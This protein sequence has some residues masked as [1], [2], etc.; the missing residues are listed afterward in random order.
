[1]ESTR[2]RY[3][4]S[5]KDVDSLFPRA[6]LMDKTIKRGATVSDT[7][8]FIPQAV[9]MTR[10]QTQKLTD[11]FF[12]GYDLRETCRRIVDFVY[13][14]IN[15]RKDEDGLEQIRS[16]RRSWH[17][18]LTGV[19][20]DCYTTFISTI[21]TNLRIKHKLRIAKYSEDH[22]QHIYP[23][24]PLPQG[25]YLTLDC[26]PMPRRFNYEEPYTE[27]KDTN[28]NLEF[29]DG[30]PEDEML[31]IDDIEGLGKTKLGKALKKGLHSFNRVNPATIAL[32]NGLLAAMKL[33]TMNIAG[34]IRW[35]YLSE[36]EAVAKGINPAKHR[37]LRQVRERLEKIFYGAGG[38]EKNLKSA[39]L[40]GKGN[41][42]HA[43]RGFGYIDPMEMSG[44]EG[45]DEYTPLQQVLGKE[46]WESENLSGMDGFYDTDGMG[47]LGAG[48]AIATTTAALT[49]VSELLKKIGDIF[50]AKKAAEESAAPAQE[51]AGQAEPP[52]SS[53]PAES[54][55]SAPEPTAE[56]EPA[57]EENP[58]PDETQGEDLSGTKKI[59]DFWQKHKSWMKPTMW[60]VGGL[61]LLY[62]GYRALAPGEKKKTAPSKSGLSGTP[63]KKKNRGKGKRKK[64]KHAVTLM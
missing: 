61:G 27:I 33:N 5:G 42:G 44:L 12:R 16:P 45:M 50:P 25:G 41:K 23:I 28:M 36:Q 2:K 3:L 34:R 56:E 43:V 54:E 40:K 19:D 7:V 24:V 55:P 51:E 10:W 57:A 8:K 37:K 48:V 49:T 63:R 52:E 35:S 31:G 53:P 6:T 60:G 62:F 21:L 22:F 1:M 4:K 39:I 17:E 11:Q 18:R 64:T 13:D 20:C 58:A 30:I 38:K 47:E 32:R 59:S 26:V 9:Q 46:L 14:H 15:Y 29:L